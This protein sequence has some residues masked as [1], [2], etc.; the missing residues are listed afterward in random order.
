MNGRLVILWIAAAMFA[1]ATARLLRVEPPRNV[2][3][4]FASEPLPEL[5]SSRRLFGIDCP[6]C[7][8]TRSFIYASRWR[9][10]DAW[11]SNPAGAL[12]FA[13][14]ALSIPW[15]LVQWIQSHRG[16]WAPTSTIMEAGWLTVI[17]IVMMLHWSFRILT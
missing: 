16:R 3:T 2:F 6:G 10:L 5:C 11:A 1:I 13:S 4:P 7:G 14:I 17:A 15:R 9:W 8:M 12:L